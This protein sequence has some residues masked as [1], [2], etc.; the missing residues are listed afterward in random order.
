[1]VDFQLLVQNGIS[2]NTY[3]HMYICF[4]FYIV[5]TLYTSSVFKRISYMC[6]VN[7]NGTHTIFVTSKS[8]VVM[9][10][11]DSCIGWMLG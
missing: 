8:A 3:A 6:I 4:S 2:W 10:A 7:Y 5:I 11:T 9:G 1:M